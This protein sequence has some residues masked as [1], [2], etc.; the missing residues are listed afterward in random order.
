MNMNKDN[1]FLNDSDDSCDLDSSKI[2]DNCC[3]CVDDY[4]EKDYRVVRIDGIVKDENPQ[5]DWDE[6][7]LEDETLQSDSD[8]S[9]DAMSDVEYIEDIPSLREEYDEKINK[10]LGRK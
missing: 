4:Q 6:Y 7:I 2:C 1:D 5:I 3:K 9:E 8:A 10:F